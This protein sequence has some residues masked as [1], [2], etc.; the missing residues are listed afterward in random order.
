MRVGDGRQEITSGLTRG[1]VPALALKE[2]LGHGCWT[3]VDL[4]T[5][6]QH[7]G[8]VEFVVDGLTGLVD[9]DSMCVVAHGG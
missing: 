5:F 7:G 2:G 8:L 1:A 3:K 4:P 6:V 9:G